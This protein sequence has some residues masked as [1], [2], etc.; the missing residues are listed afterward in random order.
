MDATHHSSRKSPGAVAL[1]VGVVLL[2]LLA[3]YL[4]FEIVMIA[5][6]AV[7]VALLLHIGAEPWRRWGK[8]P[9]WLSLVLSGLVIAVLVATLSGVSLG[10][11]MEATLI[12]A[13]MVRDYRLDLVPGF[14][15]ELDPQITLRPKHGV[16]VVATKRR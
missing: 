6:G 10:G 14:P 5:L 11:L 13:T 2:V 7:I 12:L 1:R 8:L 3:V 15:I 16:R 9:L 4:L